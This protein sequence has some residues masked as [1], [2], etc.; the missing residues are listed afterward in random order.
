M[1]LNHPFAV[2]ER[3]GVTGCASS[4][5]AKLSQVSAM[6]GGIRAAQI[7]LTVFTVAGGLAYPLILAFLG[8]A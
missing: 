5:V 6:H 3:P 7:L 4:L 2:T 1:Y 8:V